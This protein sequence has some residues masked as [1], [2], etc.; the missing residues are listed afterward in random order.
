M[1]L[2]PAVVTHC[3]SAPL[4]PVLSCSAVLELRAVK[5]PPLPSAAWGESSGCITEEEPLFAGS[6]GL[7]S[8][9]PAG[10]AARHI[11]KNLRL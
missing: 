9:A 2:F 5:A 4:L 1:Q 3:L 8:L 7:G 11:Q 6:H 10:I